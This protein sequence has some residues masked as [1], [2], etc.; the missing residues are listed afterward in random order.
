[1]LNYLEKFITSDDEIEEVE[2]KLF[3]YS[4]LNELMDIIKNIFKDLTVKIDHSLK[5]FE[6]HKKNNKNI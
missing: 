2:K 5:K 1:M 4:N 3:D 6:L